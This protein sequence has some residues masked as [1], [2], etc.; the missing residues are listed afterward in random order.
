ML[1]Y[2]RTENPLRESLLTTPIE[3]SEGCLPIPTGPGL[4]VDVDEER[5][6]FYSVS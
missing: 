5:L 2:D 1:E 3:M 4:G 6:A